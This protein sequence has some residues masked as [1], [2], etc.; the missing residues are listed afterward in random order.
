MGT[1]S[2]PK[3]QLEKA[4]L[5]LEK[6]K[7]KDQKRPQQI[8]TLHRIF[9]QVLIVYEGEPFDPSIFPNLVE[10]EIEEKRVLYKQETLREL[11]LMKTLARDLARMAFELE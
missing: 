1:Y 3:N 9:Y 10:K 8:E 2:S 5:D 7:H 6:L 4:M 11:K